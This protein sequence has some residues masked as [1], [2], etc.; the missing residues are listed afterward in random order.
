MFKGSFR[1]LY[2]LGVTGIRKYLLYEY[3]GEAKYPS[4]WVRLILGGDREIKNKGNF[5]IE[6]EPEM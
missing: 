4:K 5:L 2:V 6:Y 3:T 1:K